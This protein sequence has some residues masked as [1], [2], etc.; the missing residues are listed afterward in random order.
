M[1]QPFTDAH[2]HFWDHTLPGM[3]WRFLEPDFVRAIGPGRPPGSAAEAQLASY[4][5]TTRGMRSEALVKLGR[6]AEAEAEERRAREL[7]AIALEALKTPAS[8][9]RNPAPP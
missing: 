8:A 5:A 1:T 3:R 6:T 9:P 7:R 4:L 2:V